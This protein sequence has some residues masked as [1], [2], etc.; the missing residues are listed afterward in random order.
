MIGASEYID[1]FGE[2]KDGFFGKVGTD[3]NAKDNLLLNAMKALQKHKKNPM[4]VKHAAAIVNNCFPDY[5]DEAK[6]LA[7]QLNFQPDLEFIYG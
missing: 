4:I 7:K 5:E 2:D 6:E 3:P 1:S